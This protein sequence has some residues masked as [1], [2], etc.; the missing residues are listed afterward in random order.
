MSVGMSPEILRERVYVHPKGQEYLS[1]LMENAGWGWGDCR[2]VEEWAGLTRP[3]T[4]WSG[5]PFGVIY[6]IAYTADCGRSMKAISDLVAA[7]LPEASGPENLA[8]L[9]SIGQGE[10]VS[11]DNTYAI[12]ERYRDVSQG[13]VDAMPEIRTV[14]QISYDLARA[15]SGAQ[16]AWAD[17]AAASL[18]AT[19]HLFG[20]AALLRRAFVARWS[21]EPAPVIPAEV[22]ERMARLWALHRRRQERAASSNDAAPPRAFPLK[23]R[24]KGGSRG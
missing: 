12:W 2:S 20:Y 14:L 15:S 22:S 4:A 11:A 21:G 7:V 24:R 1:K 9:R 10:Q 5:I 13:I 18:E 23:R 8:V 16:P 17:R 6:R 3:G 19:Y